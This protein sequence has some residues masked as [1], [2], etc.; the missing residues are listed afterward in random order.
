MQLED[1]SRADALATVL[2]EVSMSP[3]GGPP[4]PFVI[5]YPSAQIDERMRYALRATI[6]MGDE[7]LF[8]N[9][10]YIDPFTGNPVEVLVRKVPRS[11]A[12]SGPGLEDTRW[13]LATLGAAEVGPGAGGN[14]VDLTLSAEEQRAAGFSGCNRYSGAYSREGDSQHGT[15]LKIGPTA[16]T[17]MACPEGME[18]EQTYLQMLGKVDA[19]RLVDGT[20]VLLAG[21][22]ELATFTPLQD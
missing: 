21:G 22:E 17:M 9:T 14:P 4:Y 3:R 15:P 6:R 10:D 16:G 7:L 13:G 5:D 20:L 8:T 19:F 2:V 18:L 1:I 12:P 11:P